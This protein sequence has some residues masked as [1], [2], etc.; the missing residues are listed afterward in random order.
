M[1]VDSGAQF[2]GVIGRRTEPPANSRLKL[3]SALG[4]PRSSASLRRSQLSRK[5]VGRIRLVMDRESTQFPSAWHTAGPDVLW[6]GEDTYACIPYNLLPEL[7]V[8]TFDGGFAWLPPLPAKNSPLQLGA[9]GAGVDVYPLADLVAEAHSLRLEIPPSLVRFVSTPDLFSR[10][11]SC[12]ACYLDFSDGLIEDPSDDGGRM[13][14]F[15]NDSQACVLW[16]LYLRPNAEH[17]VLTSSEWHH[18]FRDHADAVLNPNLYFWCAPHF[19]HF[20]YRFWLENQIWRRCHA[21][22]PLSPE[23]ARYFDAAR[24]ARQHLPASGSPP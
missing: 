15:M 10:V 18:G 19:E 5:P 14:R 23:E 6:E 9:D 3:T 20:I 11:P 13:L 16:Y 2:G 1:A 24:R 8:T 17:C 4:R 21:A 12:T 7:E 22:E